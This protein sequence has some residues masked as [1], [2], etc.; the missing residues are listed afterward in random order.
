MKNCEAMQSDAV[1]DGV[2][3]SCL[4]ATASSTP[5][6]IHSHKHTDTPSPEEGEHIIMT[7]SYINDQTPV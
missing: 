6:F 5:A 1:D 3:A 2:A 7:T 4:H